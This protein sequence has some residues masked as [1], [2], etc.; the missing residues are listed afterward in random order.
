MKY[1]A[2]RCTGWAILILV[3]TGIIGLSPSAAQT[4]EIRPGAPVTGNISADTPTQLWQL[5]ATAGQQLT[6]LVNRL[7]GDLDPQVRVLDAG[8]EVVAEN[9]DRLAS[10]VLDSGLQVEFDESGSYIVE[11]GRRSGSGDYRLWLMPGYLRVW[12][13]EDFEENASRWVDR[14]SQQQNG[15]LL[16]SGEIEFAIFSTMRGRI[17]LTDFYVQADFEWQS[18]MADSGATTGLV[19][20]VNEDGTRRP[21][22]YYFLV[23]PDGT[24]QVLIRQNDQFI[25]L[26]PPTASGLLDGNQVTLGAWLEGETLRFYA[27]GELLG[28]FEDSTFTQGTWGFQVRGDDAPAQVAVDHVLLTVPET[29]ILRPPETLSTWRS[30]QPSEVAVELERVRLVGAGGERV[31]TVESQNYEIIPRFTRIFPQGDADDIFVDMLVSVDVRVLAG[32]NVGCG[33]ALRSMDEGNQVVAYADSDGGTGLIYTRDGVVE[34][35]TYDLLPE[36]EDPIS[37]GI[38]RLLILLRGDI[39]TMYVNG[40]LFTTEF[41]P[42]AAG[43]IAVILLNYATDNPSCLF[44]DLWVWRWP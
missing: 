3:V 33:L 40:Q 23:T 37:A 1:P 15:Q 36:I 13:D 41:M 29:Q 5:N 32:Q 25:E 17:P 16:I 7:S 44:E 21:P 19:L 24:W 20:R 2:P 31:L 28:E 8:G 27:N 38:T 10:L 6:I 22:G 18:D 35:H 43:Q 12:E 42:P 4:P 34:K 9:D 11:V 14:N 26:Q 30:S 39:V